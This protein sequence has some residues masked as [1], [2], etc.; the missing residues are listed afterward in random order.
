MTVLD[1]SV[2]MKWAL[3]ELDSNKALQLRAEFQAGI[4]ALIAPDI[5]IAE[6]ANALT[7]AERKRIIQPP[8]G[9]IHL[10]DILTSPPMLHPHQPLLDRAFD[11]SSAMRHAFYDCVYSALA[12]REGCDFISADDKLVRKLQPHFPF[13]LALASLP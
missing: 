12:E 4:R 6:I 7:R 1:P 8:Q 10:A 2:A 9:K 5:F 11:I 3:I 13:V